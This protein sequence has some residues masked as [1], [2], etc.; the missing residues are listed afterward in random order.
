MTRWYELA[1]WCGGSC[2]GAVVVDDGGI[3]V[4]G[5]VLSLSLGLVESLGRVPSKRLPTSLNSCR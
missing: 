1:A 2:L 3:E 4:A 5:L